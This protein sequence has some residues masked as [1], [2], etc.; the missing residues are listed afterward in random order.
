MNLRGIRRRSPLAL[1]VL[2]AA[3]AILCWG[4]RASSQAENA[5]A[6]LVAAA[7]AG[8]M[9]RTQAA[10]VAGATVDTRDEDG[11]TP[12]MRACEGG[13]VALVRLLLD[14]GAD[15]NAET[16]KGMTPLLLAAQGF[17]VELSLEFD[18][19]RPREPIS[20]H[21]HLGANR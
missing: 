19:A 2:T 5:N 20:R 21:G 4:G 6:A 16:A 9:P 10:L 11:A 17:A 13:H 1:P 14:K 7:K 8:D 12:L 3:V 15:V 18:Q